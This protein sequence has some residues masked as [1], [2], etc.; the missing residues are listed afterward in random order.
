MP[1][2]V[3]QPEAST[4]PLNEFQRVLDVFIAPTK[5]FNDIQRSAMWWGPF[6]VMLI[7]SAAFSWTVGQKVGW[8]VAFQNQ[9]RMNP[10]AQARLEQAEASMPADRLAAV[11]SSQAKVTEISSYARPVIILITVAITALLVWPTINFGFGGRAKYSQVFAVFMYTMLIP[12]VLK[13]LLAIVAL[14]AGVAQD[15]FFLPNP[16]G[17]NVGYYLMGGDSPYWLVVLGMF[18]DV[19]G[20]WSLVVSV[21]GCSIVGRVKRSSAAIAVVGWWVVTVLLFTGLAAL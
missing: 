8:N 17:T 13:Y 5:L 18:I 14:Y 19:L 3:I 20:I 7:V 12:E 11:Q 21:M 16:V 1:E 15:S 6:V 10:K 4:Q 9:I 2:A